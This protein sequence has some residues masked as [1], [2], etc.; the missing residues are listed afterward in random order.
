MSQVLLL[1]TH[2]ML[3][4]RSYTRAL[5][6]MP[7]WLVK[8]GYPLVPSPLMNGVTSRILKRIALQCGA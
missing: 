1:C 4:R 5:G 8:R 2:T 3:C 7:Y 6:F